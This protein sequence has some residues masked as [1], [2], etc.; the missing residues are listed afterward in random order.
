MS[1]SVCVSDAE[2][3]ITIHKTYFHAAIPFSANKYANAPS[4]SFW[5]SSHS[6]TIDEIVYFFADSERSVNRNAYGRRPRGYMCHQFT[7]QLLSSIV[8]V[9]MLMFMNVFFA[10]AACDRARNRKREREGSLG[11]ETVHLNFIF[12]N[13]THA[14]ANET[15]TSLSTICQT[16]DNPT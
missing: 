8:V 16:T 15:V 4:E 6:L 2:A 10:R 13:S 5:F 14:M 9:L 3:T 11:E 7:V 1:H 12:D